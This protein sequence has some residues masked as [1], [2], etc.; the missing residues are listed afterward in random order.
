VANDR[1][2]AEG[3]VPTHTNE[4]ALVAVSDASWRDVSP[5]RRQEL[6]LGASAAVVVGAAVGAVALLRRHRR[7]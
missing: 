4:E 1:L 7:S 5:R 2:R 3:W 6:A